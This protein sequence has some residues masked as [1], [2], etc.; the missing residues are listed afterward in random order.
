MGAWLEHP[1]SGQ[2]EVKYDDP[3]VRANRIIVSRTKKMFEVQAKQ[4]KQF[5]GRTFKVQTGNAIDTTV[6]QARE[7]ANV[8][9]GQI[10]RGE[11]PGHGARKGADAGGRLGAVQEA[12]RPPTVHAG[13]VRTGIPRPGTLA[14][15]ALRWLV[16]NPKEAHDEHQ[17]ATEARGPSSANHAFRLLR[18]I[19]LNA[20]K[21]DVSLPRDRHPC[22]AVK[23]NQEKPRKD[24]AIPAADMPEWKRQLDALRAKESAAGCLPDA[25]PSHRLPTR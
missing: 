1:K 23:W 12:N 16:D 8:I 18:T 19:Y 3:S 6:G 10:L 15:K 4:P 14:D 11:D 21:L 25:T 24:A 20:A 9:L 13:D 5:G 7:R 2:P 17:R 22:S